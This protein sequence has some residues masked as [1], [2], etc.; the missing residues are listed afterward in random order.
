[1]RSHPLAGKKDN[2]EKVSDYLVSPLSDLHFEDYGTGYGEQSIRSRDLAS[3]LT[4]LSGHFAKFDGARKA[5]KAQV[6]L[7]LLGGSPDAAATS[8]ADLDSTERKSLE[9]SFI[10]SWKANGFSSADE[11]QKF[12]NSGAVSV[13]SMITVSGWVGSTRIE[14]GI[15]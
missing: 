6:A 12:M 3:A 4:I 13:G 11:A 1:L 7:A 5:F 8:L 9:S 2:D 10:G 14:V 15:S